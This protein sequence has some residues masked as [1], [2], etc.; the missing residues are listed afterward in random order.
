MSPSSID[1]GSLVHTRA[2]N[3]SKVNK[4]ATCENI[5]FDFSKHI[6]TLNESQFRLIY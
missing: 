2:N 6:K 3:M 4:I 1:F 5:L